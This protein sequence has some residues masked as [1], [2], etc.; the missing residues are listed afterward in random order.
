MT[1]KIKLDEKSY[2][3][4]LIYEIGYV[5]MKNSKYIKINNVNF[6]FLIISKVNEYFEEI[7]KN[8][9]LTPVPTNETK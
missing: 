8:K 4:I 9:Y 3:N 6:L 2:K 7:N 5:T 1:N